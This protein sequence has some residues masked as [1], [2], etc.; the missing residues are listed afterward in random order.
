MA[1]DDKDWLIVFGILVG[2]GL[3]VACGW[4][5]RGGGGS[6]SVQRDDAGRIVG[7]G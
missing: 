4:M 6:V 1:V 2:F 5:M 7:W 3:G